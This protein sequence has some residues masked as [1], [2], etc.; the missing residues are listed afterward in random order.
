MYVAI[1]KPTWPITT[2]AHPHTKDVKLN[3]YKLNTVDQ[4]N[5]NTISICNLTDLGNDLMS[6]LESSNIILALSII[7]FLN[8][9][10][11]L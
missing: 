9:S 11:I 4:I 8:L 10:N 1:I 5:D 3:T 6:D 2:P 7:Q